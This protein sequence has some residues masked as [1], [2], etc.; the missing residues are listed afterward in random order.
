MLISTRVRFILVVIILVVMSSAGVPS[1]HAQTPSGALTVTVADSTGAR[2]AGATVTLSRGIERRLAT[3][4]A[5]GVA[6]FAAVAPG[7]WSLSVASEGFVTSQQIVTVAEAVLD[8][9]VGLAVAGL[10]ESVQ[11]EGARAGD[12]QLPLSAPATGG[13]RLDISVRDLPA[14]LFMVGQ[15]LIQERGARTVEE[16]VQLAVGMQASTG[17]GSIPSYAT[18]GWGGNNVG[19]LRDGIRQNSSSQSSRPVDPFMLDRVEILKGPASLLYSEGSIGGAVNMVSKSP[20]STPALDA[21]LAYGSYGQY[22]TGIGINAPLRQNLFARVDVSQ[23]GSDGYVRDSP[24]KLAAAAASLRWLPSS[25]VSIKATAT[26][27]YDDTSAYYATPFV[28]GTFDR[29]MRDI[30]YNMSD[31]LTKSHNRWMQVESDA[32]FAGSWQFTNQFFVA[33]HALDWRNYEGYAYNAATNTVDVSSYFLIWRNDLLVGDRGFVRNRFTV[34]GRDVRVMFGGEFQR[35]DMERAGNP[36]PNYVVPTVKLDPFNPTPHA[37]PGFGYVR[38]RDV[39]IETS[40]LFAETVAEVAPRLQLVGGVRWEQI[41]LSYTPYPSLV[42]SQQDYRPATG[43]AGAVF[44]MT[45]ASNLYVS[46]SRAVEPTTQLVSLD[47]SQQRFSLVPGSQ[48]EVGAKGE[49]F[50]GRLEGTFAYFSIEKRNL[51][52]TQLFD[53]IRTAQQIGQQTSRGV[54]VATVVRPVPSFRLA[55]DIAYTGAE[56]ADFIEIV[57]TANVDRSGNTPTNVPRVI[58]NIAP[59]QSIGPVD[60]TATIRHVGSRW[61]DNANTRKVD[62]FTVIDLAVGYRVGRLGRIMV[63]GRNLTD[64][65]YTQSVSNTSGRLEPPRSVDVTFSMNGWRSR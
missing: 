49:A 25:N 39:L 31:R 53:G 8:V 28:N 13:S 26:Y 9:P 47:G 24:Q 14:S 12:T 52:V 41:G 21:V 54:E 10:S 33:T 3:T 37:D 2:I 4:G 42:T 29:R 5:D 57:G 56:F 64:R 22:R 19:L 63:R 62:G 55:A 16:T 20:L 58:W 61:G 18:R 35:N 60:V 40:A 11:V 17:V 48:I 1:S 45:P 44:N 65:I 15:P 7:E 38:Q 34:G 6:R 59:T 46:Y 30:N 27:T 51:L 43:R 50:R 36:T 23:S 32:L